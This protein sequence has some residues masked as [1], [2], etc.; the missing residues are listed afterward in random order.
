MPRQVCDSKQLESQSGAQS[1]LEQRQSMADR[2]DPSLLMM[3]DELSALASRQDFVS[4]PGTVV[5]CYQTSTVSH[6]LS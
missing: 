4:L 3:A 5:S 6:D 2:N 1:S